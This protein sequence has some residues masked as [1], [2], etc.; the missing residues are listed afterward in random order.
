MKSRGGTRMWVLPSRQAILS[1]S[2]TCCQA[3]QM[4][5]QQLWV[6]LQVYNVIR[7]LMAQTACNAG[8]ELRGLGFTHTEYG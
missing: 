8:V 4:N 1:L 2:T 7:L 6:H 3:P 5:E